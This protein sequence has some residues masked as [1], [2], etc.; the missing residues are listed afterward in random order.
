MIPGMGQR[1][2]CN[3]ISTITNQ[4]KLTF[5]VFAESFCT[6]V[7]LRFLQRLIRQVGARFS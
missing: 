7:L 3:K 1:V 4:G 2:G 6:A 5:L